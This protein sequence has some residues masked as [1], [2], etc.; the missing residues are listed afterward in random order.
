MTQGARDH[1]GNLEAALTV[2]PDSGELQFTGGARLGG[3]LSIQGLSGGAGAAHNL[4]G[5]HVAVTAGERRLTVTFPGPEADD[6]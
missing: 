5:Q 3:S 1:G 2:A 4:R 6:D